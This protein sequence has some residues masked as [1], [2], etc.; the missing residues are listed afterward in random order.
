V[1]MV[2]LRRP[3]VVMVLLRLQHG[4]RVFDYGGHQTI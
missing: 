1:V 2:L 3:Q 4:N